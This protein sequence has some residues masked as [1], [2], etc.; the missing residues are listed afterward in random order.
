MLWNA[1]ITDA[2]LDAVPQE[3]RQGPVFQRM[4]L[5]FAAILTA[6]CSLISVRLVRLRKQLQVVTEAE[7]KEDDDLKSEA[8]SATRARLRDSTRAPR[9]RLAPVLV[10]APP[11]PSHP[12]LRFLLC[13]V[14]H[15]SPSFPSPH[16]V[17]SGTR[18]V[19]RV[20]HQQ[21]TERILACAT[22]PPARTASAPPASQLVR[23]AHGCLSKHSATSWAARGRILSSRSHRS[24]SF[25]HVKLASSAFDFRIRALTAHHGAVVCSRS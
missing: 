11:R 4:L 10:A 18:P 1:S 15:S 21:S 2:L 19:Q 3:Q 6:A 12:L 14:L 20:G 17:P 13:T 8:S 23:R 25:Q 7:G 5:F 22:R 16:S 24:T 9:T